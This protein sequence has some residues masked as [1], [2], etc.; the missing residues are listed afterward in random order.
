MKKYKFIMNRMS[1]AIAGTSL[2]VPMLLTNVYAADE[3]RV[4]LSSA[5]MSDDG[6]LEI[7]GAS[8]DSTKDTVS[9]FNTILSKGR[10]IISGVTGIGA[11]IM[12]GF[13]LW[14]TVRLSK[15]GDNPSERSKCINGLIFFFIGAALF[16]SASLFSGLFYNMFK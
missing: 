15:S 1:G 8:G 4:D 11:L 16:G 13:F 7:A 12:V 2:A 6:T 9:V 10:V 14:F 3:E 5:K